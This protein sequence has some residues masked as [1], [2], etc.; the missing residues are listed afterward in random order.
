MHKSRMGDERIP[1]MSVCRG[2]AG[3][4]KL[5][6]NAPHALLESEL[7]SSNDATLCFM[8]WLSTY[9]GEKWLGISWHDGLKVKA[10]Q[11]P[12]NSQ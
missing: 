11:A 3:V 12:N 6:F 1:K 5:S 8:L 7:Y 9:G 2:E 4:P 10:T